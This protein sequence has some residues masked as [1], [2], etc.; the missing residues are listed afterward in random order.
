[1][2]NHRL[3]IWENMFYLCPTTEQANLRSMMMF[4]ERFWSDVG[5]GDIHRKPWGSN[6]V[7]TVNASMSCGASGDTLNG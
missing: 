6:A 7:G 3:I 2:K 5:T 4:I 1:M